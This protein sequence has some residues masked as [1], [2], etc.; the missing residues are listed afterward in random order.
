M[1]PERSEK[2]AMT[3]V[4]GVED[5]RSH[6]SIAQAAARPPSPRAG[7]KVKQG[8]S[9]STHD[10]FRRDIVQKTWLATT[11]LGGDLLFVEDVR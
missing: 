1:F 9:S 5:D 4:C 6:F 3:T 8:V 7:G 10:P 2:N 11:S